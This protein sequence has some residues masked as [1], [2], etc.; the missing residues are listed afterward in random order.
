MSLATEVSPSAVEGLAVGR[1]PGVVVGI[2]AF[3]AYAKKTFVL[4]EVHDSVEHEV[5]S[6][7]LDSVLCA[8]GRSSEFAQWL[9]AQLSIC[10]RGERDSVER[11]RV[12]I[13]GG[14]DDELVLVD[15][16]ETGDASFVLL[17][18][19]FIVALARA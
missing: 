18:S 2:V 5:F 15:E 12:F 9:G 3:P 14:V 17:V 7:N 1:L 6:F 4:I 13:A 19:L 16:A 11:Y 10:H 8:P